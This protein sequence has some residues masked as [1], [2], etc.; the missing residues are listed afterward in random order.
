MKLEINTSADNAEAANF[1]LARAIESAEGNPEFKRFFNLSKRHS[2]AAK[3]FRKSLV[4]ALKNT[5][6]E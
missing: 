6:H 3:R 2:V 5:I 4:K 1:F